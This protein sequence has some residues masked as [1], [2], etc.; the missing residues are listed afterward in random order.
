MPGSQGGSTLTEHVQLEQAIAALEA[1]RS[2]LGDAVVDAAIGSIQERL[3]ALA[4]TPHTEQRKL[5]TVLFADLVGWTSMSEQMDP[6]EL[7]ELQD[8]YFA[9]VTRPIEAYGGSVEKYIGDA[10]L[11]VFGV[12]Q[13]H[14]DDAERAVHAAL[15]MQEAMTALNAHL[16]APPAPTSAPL[17]ST[18]EGPAS[19]P[20]RSTPEGLTSGSLS[21]S[22]R[23]GVHTGLVLSRV[24][25]GGDFVVSGDTVNL[26][27]RL[28]GAAEPGTVLVSADTHRLVE[29]A[30]KTLNLGTI[31]LKGKAEPLQVFRVAGPTQA[32][33]KPRGVAGLDSPLVGRQAEMAAL[34]KTLER[35]QRGVGG[36][37][38][39][40]GE[41]GIGKSRLAAEL[42]KLQA[43][44]VGGRS[45]TDHRSP[46]TANWIEGRC[47]SFG[48]SIPYLLW[49]DLLRSAL[50]VTLDDPPEVVAGRLQTWVQGLCPDRF[51]DVFPYLARLMSLPLE[52]ETLADLAE[53][54][55]QALKQRTFRAAEIALASAATR[56]PLVLVCE[57]LHWADA[58]SLELMQHLL[59]LVDRTSLLFVCVF[60]PHVEH[61]SWN[62]RDL[63]GRDYRH[64]YTDLWL[65]PLSAADSE[66]L[67]GNLLRVDAL[68]GDLRWRILS[69]AEGNPFFVEE[70]IRTLIDVQAIAYDEPS[71]RWLAT[72]DLAEVPIPET[73]QGVIAARI[74][75]LQGDTRH[76]L[77]LASVIGRIFLYR[78]LASIA[79][80]ERS[81]DDRL[82]ALQRQELIRERARIPELEYIFKHELTREAAYNGILKKQ[83][84]LFHR[85]VAEALER[86]FPDR[87]DELAG[88]LAHHWE[89]AGDVDRAVTCLLRA[90]DRARLAY[91]TGEAVDFYSRAVPL[92]EPQGAPHRLARVLMKLGT[93]Y[94]SGFDFDQSRQAYG[95]AFALWDERPAADHLPAPHALRRV[96][97]EWI[98][99]D[100]TRSNSMTDLA[101]QRALFSG[102]T[103]MD[104][105]GEVV[106]E[107]ARRWRILDGGRT[108]VFEL[109]EDAC[110]SNGQ[111]VTARDFE[112]AW[113]RLLDPSAPLYGSRLLYGIKGAEAYHHGDTAALGV[114][115][116]DD[117]TLV[118]QLEE[119]ASYFLHLLGIPTLFAVPH[120]VLEACGEAWTEAP[121]LVTSGPFRLEARQ[122]GVSTTLVRNPDF[123]G[124]F[125]G[126][127]ERVETL[128]PA[129][130]SVLPALYET[131]ELDTLALEPEHVAWA[132]QNYAGEYR[133]MPDVTTYF[134]A[135]HPDQPPFD[136][137]RVRRAFVHA[138]DRSE[139]PLVKAG[140]VQPGTG[141][142]VPPGVPG[143]TPGIGLAHDPG[144]AHQLMEQAGYPGGHG[145]P[146]VSFGFRENSEVRLGRPLVKQ[147]RQVLGVQVDP[148][149]VDLNM[150]FYGPF[151]RRFPVRLAGWVGAL[152]DPDY[153]LRLGIPILL[154]GLD[155][156]TY[157]RLLRAA[158]HSGDQGERL[159]LFGRADRILVEQA[160]VAPLVYEASNFLSKPWLREDYPSLRDTII[161]PH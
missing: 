135:F 36:I 37:V 113:K 91:A 5:V 73:L 111:P 42:R 23:I 18:P 71:G 78:V 102:L 108:Y 99:L 147:W 34:R 51:P 103:Y 89:R 114:Q 128:H 105:D 2:M 142:F 106:P 58:S 53:L 85:Q 11:A 66:A 95:R 14:E 153:F 83:R 160:L 136:D 100:P 118:V 119:P 20:L 138:I 72:R 124:L 61:S 7:R 125:R 158:Q 88:L 87:L 81:L 50:D 17:Q 48:A 157:Y 86:L 150:A 30:F 69:R 148:Q 130:T 126:N 16:T 97:P 161:E 8:A 129:D 116:Q 112:Y 146:A 84:K 22:L 44:D 115:V 76:V 38:T 93:T 132:Q 121:N 32:P 127:V 145:F 60:R 55:G 64:R 28:Q 25:E 139:L 141:G 54:D 19:D 1:Q 45:T 56:Q 101:W 82:L 75:R 63:V 33:T 59:P 154:P 156:P 149:A 24:N 120:L 13:S 159:E 6:E 68:P 29:R 43:T 40:V 52:A 77:Q 62:F 110:W 27:S 155:N 98:R 10:V 123:R 9:A 144:L 117:A 57:D 65:Q 31:E 39:V 151:H 133:H 140:I 46:V 26:A 21:L 109:R 90:G 35:L 134:L 152:R 3:A 122:P 94:H 4:P 143:H 70:V 79:Q 15:A 67:V 47:L 41:A 104:V 12:P 49:L 74:D 80:E 92:L 107:L 96:R 131:G 137:A